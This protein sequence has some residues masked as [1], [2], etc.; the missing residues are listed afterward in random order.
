M[1][2]QIPSPQTS[3]APQ[4]AGQVIS[5]P[6]SQIPL[7]HPFSTQLPQSTGQE[8]QSSLAA[9]KPSPHTQAL[10]LPTHVVPS[11]MSPLVQGSPSSQG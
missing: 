10:F 6:T 11:Q 8:L 2:L 3:P 1:P 9:Q 4:S 7:P 5:S